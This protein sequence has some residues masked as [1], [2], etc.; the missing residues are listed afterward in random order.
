M[1]SEAS[2]D[3]KRARLIHDPSS[4]YYLHPSEGPGNSLTKF[5]LKCDNFDIWEKA[6]RNALGG[7]GKSIFLS[8]VDVPK[9]VDEN[10]LSAWYANHQII[11]S[12]IFNSVD[13]SIQPSIVSHTISSEL[14]DDLRKRY[15]CSNGPRI[16]QL[17]SELTSLRQKGQSVVSYY[18]QFIT[19]WKQLNGLSDPTDGCKCEAAVATRAR[20][21]RDKTIDFLLGLDDEQFGNIR[22]QILGTEPVPDIDR[23]YYLISQE[24]RHCG[25]IRARDDRTESVAFATR[26]DRRPPSSGRLLCS[27]CGRTNH[28]VDTCFE[29]VGFPAHYGR[30]GGGRGG[31]SRGGRSG[32]RPGG[33]RPGGSMGGRHAGGFGHHA[34]SRG[35]NLPS[36]TSAEVSQNNANS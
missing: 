21:E 31:A 3:T 30:G 26:Q 8:P 34:A 29:L 9:P 33:V 22:S 1:A 32:S 17:K 6:I 13:E 27:H 23:A 7:R 14:W 36:H 12:W 28:N 15:S 19:L 16:Y 18:N 24:E 11:C 5:L 4:I 25:I 20:I 10:E 2:S 35:S